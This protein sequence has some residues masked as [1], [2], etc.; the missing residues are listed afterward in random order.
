M[1]NIIVKLIDTNQLFDSLYSQA[2]VSDGNMVSL[3]DI[4]FTPGLQHD[5]YDYLNAAEIAY[6][7]K[8]LE[9]IQS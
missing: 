8:V 2:F 3:V 5:L 4:I 1:D 6:F 7:K 9:I